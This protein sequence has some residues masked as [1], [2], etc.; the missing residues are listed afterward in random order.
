MRWLALV[1]IV[2]CERQPRAADA[3]ATPTIAPSSSIAISAAP[4][5]NAPP[6][7]TGEPLAAL[8]VAGFAEAIVSLPLGTKRKRPIVLACHG[9]YD[10]PEWQCATWRD[11]LA[12]AGKSAFVLCPRGVA[13]SDSPS[14]DDVRFTYASAEAMH[15]ELDAGL[16]ALREKYGPFVDEGPMVFTGFSLGSIYGA[17]YVLRDP[18]KLPRVVLTEGSHDKWT[19]A[20]VHAFAKKGG[21][22]ALFPCGQP[23]CVTMATPVTK[24][25]VANGVPARVVHGKGVGHGYDGA[26]ADE[27]VK[28]LDWVL[29]GDPRFAGE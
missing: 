6:A 20:A 18:A 14:K 25:F 15:R 9:N 2:G 17:P 16:A 10:R 13:R 19:P 4:S 23:G 5:A 26:V 1:V 8:P 27:I 29:D 28:V 7:L 3:A 22:R 12:R 21:V 11:I 24:A